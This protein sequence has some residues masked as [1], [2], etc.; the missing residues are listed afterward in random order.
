MY[1]LIDTTL[2]LE[3]GDGTKHF[4][5]IGRMM[6]AIPNSGEECLSLISMKTIF[7]WTELVEKVFHKNT[8]IYVIW[9]PLMS[10]WF[11]E[12]WSEL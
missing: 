6:V 9:V 11:R 7:N 10:I 3:T 12:F 2:T 1:N 5:N 4:L 8:F